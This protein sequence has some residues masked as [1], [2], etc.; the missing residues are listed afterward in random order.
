[1][2]KIISV[3]IAITM[4][5][6]CS[7]GDV[8]EEGSQSGK[9]DVNSGTFSAEKSISSENA[10]EKQTERTIELDLSDSEKTQVTKVTLSGDIGRRASIKDVYGV[11]IISSDLV[12]LFGCPV[13]V[14]LDGESGLLSFEVNTDN[15]DN[16][17]IENLI[18]LCK[19][20]DLNDDYQQIKSTLSGNVITAE[21][22]K[23]DVYM[24]ADCY[25][26]F[27]AW[28]IDMSEYGYDSVFTSDEFSFTVSVPKGISYSEVSGSWEAQTQMMQKT[29]IKQN[30]SDDA[31][32]T[33]SLDAMRFPNDDDVCQDP[34]PI[35]DLDDVTDNIISVMSD[36]ENN[37]CQVEPKQTFELAENRKGYILEIYI[38]ND[39]STGISEQTTITGYYEYS[40]DTYIVL[41]Y[42][43][44]GSDEE[45]VKK[46][47]E[48]IR[49]FKYTDA[50][51]TEKT[52]VTSSEKKVTDYSERYNGAEVAESA[53]GILFSCDGMDFSMD[54]PD[55]YQYDILDCTPVETDDGEKTTNLIE[56]TSGDIYS[57]FI[58]DLADRYSA[59]IE[60]NAMYNLYENTLYYCTAIEREEYTMSNGGKAYIMKLSRDEKTDYFEDED[61]VYDFYGFYETGAGYDVYTWVGFTIDKNAS[62]EQCDKLY[63]CLKSFDCTRSEK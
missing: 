47:E 17:P 5:G 7:C 2:K 31:D 60:A 25:Q 33:V 16:I 45:L 8:N 22:E 4:L 36:L 11:D 3:I 37:A 57:G 48:S 15:M 32:M 43:M 34:A 19:N 6:L 12:G 40:E 26:W 30:G 42:H 28:G 55:G 59:Y 62:K 41:G 52:P 58:Y 14:E 24:L 23:S 29:L 50:K 56:I 1:M 35:E 61:G 20:S 39:S 51:T 38:P 44:W 21:I 18:V 54:I 10:Q 53:N 13:E 27:S 63:D 49:S 9:S 46:A